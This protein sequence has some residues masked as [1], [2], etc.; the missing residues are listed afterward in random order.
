MYIAKSCNIPK[1][2]V[3]AIA[4]SRFGYKKNQKDFLDNNGEVVE[5]IDQLIQS[6]TKDVMSGVSQQK[7]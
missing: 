4:Q 2:D 5:D 6:S 3:E 1:I 7:T